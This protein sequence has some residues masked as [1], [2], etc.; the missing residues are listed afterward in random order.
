MALLRKFAFV[1]AVGG[2]VYFVLPGGSDITSADAHAL[3]EEGAR[4]ID[5]RTPAEFAA[6]HVPG[7]VNV[8]LDEV[9][10]RLG[11]FGPVDAPVVLYC[12]SGNRSGKAKRILEDAGHTQVRNLGA[13]SNW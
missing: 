9:P 3:V 7:A 2:A 4:L 8:P 5:V 13:M 11:E 6:G 12:Q 10:N 1:A